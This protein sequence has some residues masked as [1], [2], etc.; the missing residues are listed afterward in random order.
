VDEFF[1]WVVCS[2]LGVGSIMSAGHALLY[3]R[4]PRSALGWI[5]VCLA[6]PLFGPMLYWSMGINW[7]RRTARQWQERGRFLAG[8]DRFPIHQAPAVPLFSLGDEALLELCTL[9]DQVVSARLVAGNRLRP[10]Q[11]G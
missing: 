1:W 11:N 7:L 5:A 8:E 9:A 3:K 10:L 4:D 2:M 6:L